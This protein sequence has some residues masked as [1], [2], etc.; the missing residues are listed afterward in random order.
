[1]IQHK[2]KEGGRAAGEPCRRAGLDVDQDRI[3]IGGGELR[4]RLAARRTRI[5]IE[6]RQAGGVRLAGRR[7]RAAERAVD[8]M[9][10]ACFGRA[11]AGG[12]CRNQPRGDRVEQ[13]R[14]GGGQVLE[15]RC[16]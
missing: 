3:L 2:G 10:G 7:Q 11:G 4:E 6:R 12:V 1:V 13:I 16:L 14:L 15:R 9:D 8:V 5:S